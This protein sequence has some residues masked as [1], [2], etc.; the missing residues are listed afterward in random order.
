MHVQSTKFAY[1]Q[2]TTF[3][4]PAF[5][6]NVSTLE[7]EYI[8]YDTAAAA[9]ALINDTQ[10]YGIQYYDPTDYTTTAEGGTSHMAVVDGTGMAVSLTTTVNLYWYEILDF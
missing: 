4:D 10:T 3:G 1:G 7:R 9:R 8:Q 6:A 5:T 2:R